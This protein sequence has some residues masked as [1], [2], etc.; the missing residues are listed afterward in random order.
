M[1]QIVPNPMSGLELKLFMY[2]QEYDLEAFKQKI[3]KSCTGK[4]I[5]NGCETKNLETQTKE[6]RGTEL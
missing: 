5:P 1:C 4:K 2:I 6:G 3:G